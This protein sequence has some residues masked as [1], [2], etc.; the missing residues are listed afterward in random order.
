MSM[1]ATATRQKRSSG[2]K[3]K[4]FPRDPATRYAESVVSG[5]LVVNRWVRLACERHL[6]DLVE[7]PKRGLYWDVAEV[8]RVV[9][10]FAGVLRLNGGQHEGQPFKLAPW[11]AFI[12]GSLFGWK[13]ADTGLRRFRTAYNEIAKGNGKSPV[14]AG[15]G[16]LMLTADGEPRAEVYSGAAKK[17]QAMILFRDAVAMAEQSP[18]LD[19]RIIK[20]GVNPVWALT[21]PQT[22]SFFKPVA[23]DDKQSGYR[24]HCAL[25]DE[26]HEHDDANVI[27]MMRAGSKG[28]RQALFFEITNSGWDQTSVCWR[29]HDYSTQILESF[30]GNDGPKDD[31]WFAF[32]CGLDSGD[33]YRDEKVWPKANPN[34]DISITKDYLRRQVREAEGMPAQEGV[35]RRL[36]FCEWTQLEQRWIDQEVWDRN[37]E[38]VD[39]RPLLGKPCFGGL[40]LSST[41][42]LASFELAFPN[43]LGGYDVLSHFWMPRDNILRREQQDHI[44]YE[45][46]ERQGFLTLTPGNIVDQD[47]IKQTVLQ[48]KRLYG[49]R[50]IAF[51]RWNSSKLVTELIDELGPEVMVAGTSSAWSDTQPCR[52]TR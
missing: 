12:V 27:D 37:N 45:L 40:D 41:T 48:S 47:A 22:K 16:I 17:E 18:A 49:L 43:D 15:I 50:E 32:I 36:N 29:H 19:K 21:V 2:S 9:A 33:D 34:L 25:L 42:D 14:A 46:W 24:P 51:D 39:A 20:S 26:V 8:N 7:G 44:T 35:V 3:A 28:R 23:S 11:Q 38:P 31:E 30:R 6:W 10:F 52:L 1:T 13:H 4:G 5:K